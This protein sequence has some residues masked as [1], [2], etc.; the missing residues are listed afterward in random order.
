MLGYSDSNKDA[1]IATSQ[2]EIHRAQRALRDVAAEHG[3]RL[4]IFHGRGGTVGRGGGPT[5][6]AILALP[7]GTLDGAIKLTEQG[8]VISDKYMLPTLA[9]E[10]LELTVA[11]ALQATLLHV[12]PR[13]PADQIARWDEAMDMVSAAAH[14]RTSELV[15]DP[16]LP[17][18][19][20]G[21]HARPS[22]SARSRSA[23][24]R[25]G[26]PTP[27][28]G[29]ECAARDP[30]GVR[31]DAVAADRARLVRRRQRP[32]RGSRCRAR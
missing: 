25:P 5:H 19:L 22:C 1:G 29:L 26:D 12:E 28:D 32:G 27:G 15:T 21:L 20:L 8:E 17:R 23:R 10:N 24:G 9:R 4:R 11:A 14:A 6:D 16:D 3:V 18:V 31:L 30:V 2:W 13:Q 7:Y